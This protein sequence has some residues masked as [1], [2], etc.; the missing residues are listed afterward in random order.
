MSCKITQD[1]A[2]VNRNKRS[3]ILREYS[4]NIL[5]D[6]CKNLTRS[7]KNYLSKILTRTCKNVLARIFLKILRFLQESCKKR[8]Q[9]LDKI[10]H[11][12]SVGFL[13]VPIGEACSPLQYP[14]VC[15]FVLGQSMDCP[16]KVRIH[17]LSKTIHGL[18]KSIL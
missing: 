15:H 2:R 10:L 12:I 4:C 8:C 11:D 18:S 14:S 17:T 9:I 5:K 7:C 3:Q 6:S 16:L 1:H 13:F